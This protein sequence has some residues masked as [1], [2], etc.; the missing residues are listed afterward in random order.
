[1]PT[2]VAFLVNSLGFGGAEKH[3]LQLFNSLPETRFRVA[4]GYLS[5]QEHLLPQVA[6]ERQSQVWCADFNRGWDFQ[7][8]ARLCKWLRIANPDVLVCANAYTL[9]Y[10]HLARR[11]TGIR[12][13]IIEIFHSTVLSPREDRR[14]RWVYKH[15][16]NVSDRVVYVSKAQQ[17]MWESRGIRHDIGICIQN[18]VDIEYFTDRYSSKE[19]TELR[20]RYGFAPNEFLVGICAELRPEKRHVDLIAAI[21]NLKQNGISAKCLI[22]GDG[23]CRDEVERKVRELGLG[24][25]VAITGFQEDVR[26]FMAACSCLAI[27]S[28]R[29]EAFSLAALEAMAMGKPM[30]MSSIGGAS[31]QIVEG[32]NGYLY[33]P[34]DIQSL[35]SALTSFTAADVR[36][37]LGK[38]ARRR[39][40]ALFS[41][42]S[43]LNKYEGLLLETARTRP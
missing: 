22:I 21:F 24:F 27:V 2:N 18:G 38:E 14:M 39:V 7:G 1:M 40:R 6:T 43:M 19:K 5:R 23:P 16:F 34:K 8:L 11:L 15:F 42:G 36:D 12:T 29:V 31:E 20:A 37:R 3:T 28:S 30:V 10:A 33:P 9:F 35:T 4:L 41:F 13:A 26:P 17:D 25:D 32:H